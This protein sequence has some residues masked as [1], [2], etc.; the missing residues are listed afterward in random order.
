MIVHLLTTTSEK[1]VHEYLTDK[2]G[3]NKRTFVLTHRVPND[4]NHV[5]YDV[6][7][8]VKKEV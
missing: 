4:E 5:R 7:L 2:L 3:D 8:Y 6:F 1:R